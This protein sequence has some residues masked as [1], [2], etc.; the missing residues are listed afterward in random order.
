MTD[1]DSTL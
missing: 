1:Q